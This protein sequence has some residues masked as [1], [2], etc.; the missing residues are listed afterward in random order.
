MNMSLDIGKGI[1]AALLALSIEGASRS[2]AAKEDLSDGLIGHWKLDETGGKTAADSSG[3]GH[4]LRFKAAQ[5]WE[6]GK[7]DGGL[8]FR[9]DDEAFYLNEK[10]KK[11][12]L[13]P[14][15]GKLSVSLWVKHDGFTPDTQR[16]L[17]VM[18]YVPGE[19][20]VEQAVIRYQRGQLNS[21]TGHNG[22][23]H[24]RR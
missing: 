9:G 5:P 7:I 1:V 10:D 24:L 6:K 3:H 8:R 14:P 23:K 18:Y 16:Y 4:H 19:P 13:I 2:A 20:E 22:F 21:Y 11:A 15:N 17:S 12:T